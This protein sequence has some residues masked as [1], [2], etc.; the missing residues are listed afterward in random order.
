[1]RTEALLEYLNL[2]AIV[3]F[4]FS[5]T[6][7]GFRI[8]EHPRIILLLSKL[9]SLYLIAL[10][11]ISCPISCRFLWISPEEMRAF[12]PRY[13]RINLS[14]SSST[15]RIN[16]FLALFIVNS[17]ITCFRCRNS[18][19]ICINTQKIIFGYMA[20][21]HEDWEICYECI[22]KYKELHTKQGR[23]PK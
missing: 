3:R 11:V 17:V 13:E 23:P 1:M 19:M 7:L 21:C 18:T 9:C 5:E 10:S 15:I 6:K 4:S 16:I 12:L 8:A 2:I 20:G 14:I 22:D